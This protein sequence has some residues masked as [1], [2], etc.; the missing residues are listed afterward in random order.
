MSDWHCGYEQVDE[1]MGKII[2]K[3]FENRK[4]R[5]A[6]VMVLGV[7]FILAAFLFV[8]NELIQNKA[9]LLR[10]KRKEQ[11]ILT[12]A[13]SS[14]IDFLSAEKPRSASREINSP[15]ESICSSSVRFFK[16]SRRCSILSLFLDGLPI[17]STS[18]Y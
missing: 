10:Q 9:Y 7:L 5:T 11:Q 15:E 4:S 6:A 2:N 1:V 18:Y 16:I 12:D 3:V 8:G 13:M 17:N 14:Y